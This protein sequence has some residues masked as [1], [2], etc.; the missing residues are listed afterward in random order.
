MEKI[1]TPFYRFHINLELYYFTR[2]LEILE[3]KLK[4][5]STRL[6]R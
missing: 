5:I 3:S 4:K 6:T 2:E 1:L